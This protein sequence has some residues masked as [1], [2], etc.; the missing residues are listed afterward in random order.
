[1]MAMGERIAWGSD[2]A[3]ME[4]AADHIERLEAAAAEVE[5]AVPVAWLNPETGDGVYGEKMISLRENQGKPGRL[6]ATT[7]TVPLYRHPPSAVPEGNIPQEFMDLFRAAYG[8]SFGTD[9]NR[10]THAEHYRR[11]LVEAVAKCKAMLAATGDS[12]HE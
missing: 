5:S 9:W 3:L 4:E 7:F 11:P 1:M 12:H 10:G 6:L 8:L 2:T